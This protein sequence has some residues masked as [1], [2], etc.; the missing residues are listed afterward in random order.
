MAKAVSKEINHKTSAKGWLKVREGAS[1]LAMWWSGPER[2]E[3]AKKEGVEWRCWR[4]NLLY[5]ILLLFLRLHCYFLNYAFF[6]YKFIYFI[7][8]F[9]AVLGLCCCTRAF[10]SCREQGL[11]FVVVR[12]LL[13]VVASLV[14]EHGLQARKLSSCGSRALERRL[15]SCGAR[16]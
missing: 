2:R 16:G 15:S 5:F 4:N 1:C 12:G 3:R 7:Y 9:L 11:L 14:A 6:I 13:T 10:S 8:L